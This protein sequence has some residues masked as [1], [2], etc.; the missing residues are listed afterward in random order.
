MADDKR[1]PSAELEK[2]ARKLRRQIIQMTTEAGSGHPS[3]SVSMVEILLALYRG[4]T[5]RYKPDQPD[6]PDRDRLILSK[7][8]GC[9]GL[10]AALA[11]AG[12]FPEEWLMDLRKLG[13]PL[14]G[15]PNMRRAPGVEASTGS[16]GQ[17]LSI[18]I[19]HAL[20]GRLDERDYRVYV[21]IGDGESQEGQVWEAAMSAGKFNL[22]SLTCILDFNRYQQ[23]GSVEE[24]M[25]ALKPLRDKWEAFGWH[26]I[27]IDGHDFDQV[28]DALEEARHIKYKPQFIIART[29]K[30]KGIPL[31]ENGNG[32]K[33]HG[34]PLTKEE[35]EEALA[36]LSD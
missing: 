20:A 19:G 15:H 12:Y 22:D 32:N 33:H 11:D 4:G 26:V 25:P 1:P 36:A 35:A 28:F 10:Y 13:S 9:P 31:I 17:G 30:G 7:G 8:H 34:V 27:D 16:L 6:W 21:I 5:M 23:T 24:V 2:T 18:G 14:E 3:S 29:E